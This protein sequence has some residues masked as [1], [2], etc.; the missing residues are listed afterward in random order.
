MPKVLLVEDNP[1]VWKIYHTLLLREG[2]QVDCAG[3]GE[4][5]L[6]K[7]RQDPPDLV[8]LDL[9]MPKLDGLGFLR[10]Y[11]VKHQHPQVKVVVFSNSE[12]PDE[13]REATELGAVRYMVK[14]TATPKTMLAL[15]RELLA[16]AG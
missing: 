14:Y 4:A 1:A 8:L 10:A 6:E 13:V 7:A 5:A 3:D 12:N 16:P 2:Y 9:R 11:D 15:I